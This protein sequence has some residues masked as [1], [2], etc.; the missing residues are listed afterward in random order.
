LK[1]NVRRQAPIGP[2][3]A[4]FVLHRSKLVIEIDG[5]HHTLPEQQARATRTKWLKEKGYRVI[6]FDEADVRRDV[7]V[8]IARIHAE[9][10][11]PP[12]QTLPPSSGKGLPAH[13]PDSRLA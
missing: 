5:Y 9:A 13:H 8:V 11:F 3:I 4:D 6:R 2:S 10:V 7:A 1:A 12:T